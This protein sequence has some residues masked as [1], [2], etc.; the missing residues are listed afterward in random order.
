M[1]QWRRWRPPILCM[2]LITA[3]S[4]TVVH[5]KQ[6]IQ[7]VASSSPVPVSEEGFMR[8][9]ASWWWLFVKGFH[10]LE[11]ALL[12]W[13]VL[14]ASAGR[15]TVSAVIA[16]GFATLDEFHQTFVPDRGGLITDVMIDSVGIALA[17]VAWIALSGRQVEQRSEN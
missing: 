4:S 5:S 13:L 6:L 8:F 1:S 10:V 17:C 12:T 3:M 16:L 11:F 2:A 9:W 7:S 15:I 14:R